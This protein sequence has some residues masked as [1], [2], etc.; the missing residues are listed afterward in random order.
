M[1]FA[2]FPG[3]RVSFDYPEIEVAVRRSLELL[4]A[5]LEDISGFSCCPSYDTVL[6][7]DR[8]TSITLTA[9]NLAIAE[10]SGL[11]ILTPCCECYSVFHYAMHKLRDNDLLSRVNGTL[12]RFGKVYRRRARVYHVLDAYNS[13]LMKKRSGRVERLEKVAAIHTGCHLTW[14]KKYMKISYSDVLVEVL[15]R[16]GVEVVDYSRS[17]YFCGKG[18]LRVMDP[19]TSLEFVEK[20]VRSVAE[21]TDAEMIVTP[22][23]GCRERLES[24]QKRLYEEDRIERVYPVYHVSQVVLMSLEGGGK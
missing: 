3:C 22:C 4:G 19:A 14:P 21:E 6:S 11:D 17:D 16:I 8:I 10:E 13:L 23:P 7:F 1:R 2:F 5:E 15:R 24:G 18:S 20:I 9:R 12:V